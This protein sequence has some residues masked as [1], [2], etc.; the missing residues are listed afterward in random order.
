MDPNDQTPTGTGNDP[1]FTAP[2]KDELGW[3]DA[4]NEYLE[5]NGVEPSKEDPKNEPAKPEEK[6]EGGK[7][8]E[9]DPAAKKQDEEPKPGDDPEKK[10]GGDEEPKPGEQGEEPTVRDRLKEEAELKQAREAITV[11]VRKKLFSDKPTRLEDAD[12]DPI[13]TV[14][15][16]MRLQNPRTGKPF[17]A[18]EAASWLLQAQGHLEK[19]MK[20]DQAEIDNVVETNV[21][22]KYDLEAVKQEYGELLKHMPKLRQRV[23]DA[24]LQ[25][26]ELGSDGDTIV[27]TKIGMKEFYDITLAPYMKQVEQMKADQAA[28]DKTAADAAAAKKAAEDKAAAETAR[29]NNRSDREDIFSTR[30]KIEDISDPEEK[31]WAKAAKEYYEG[32]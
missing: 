12:G 27:K 29:K 1:Q 26:V 2:T 4:T 5:E 15:D 21:A 32:N 17:T 3:V 10:A 24:F 7:T 20:A 14:A 18:E 11:D 13:E 6:P 25:T 30:T 9:G 19:Q 23:S 31:G 22:L 8:P 28:E 16:V